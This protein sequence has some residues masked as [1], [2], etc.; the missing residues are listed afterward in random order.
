MKLKFLVF[1][2][3]FLSFEII[4]VEAKSADTI[5]GDLRNAKNRIMK[6][7]TSNDSYTAEKKIKKTVKTKASKK[8]CIKSEPRLTIREDLRCAKKFIMQTMSGNKSYNKEKRINNARSFDENNN[9]ISV[10]TGT[11]DTIDKEGDDKTS[12]MG[13][14]HKN[15]DLF[16][17]TWIGRFSPTTGAFVTKKSSIYL[18]TG[19]EADYN[20][21]RINISPSFAPGYY[22]A[23]DGKKLGSALEFKSE[24]K[25]GVD[26]FKN[27][28]LGYS[29]SHI[30]NND[31]AD[32]NPGTDNQSLT[33]SK[34][35]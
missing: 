2:I 23:G 10:Y 19:I 16:R 13:I 9:N 31:W 33:L 5:R 22:E 20:I 18:Y 8:E 7:I 12:L 1:F 25:V 26:L 30:S 6:V 29:Y 4:V 27:T 15:K 17:D 35:F 28:N 21:G 34:K 24:I 14:E 32:S 11:F 3:T